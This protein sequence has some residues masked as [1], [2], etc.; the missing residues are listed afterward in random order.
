VYHYALESLPALSNAPVYSDDEE[1][2][3]G[4]GHMTDKPFRNGRKYVDSGFVHDMTD[5]KTENHYFIRAHVWPS[6]RNELPHNVL[7]ILSVN[8]GAV[9]HASCNPCKVSQLGRCSHVVA[10]LLSL[11]DHVKQHGSITSTPC[12]SKECSWNKGQKR[13]KTPKRLSSAHYPSNRKKS[14]IPV[15][16]FDPRLISCRTVT[17]DHI[18]NFVHDLQRISEDQEIS[19]WEVQ[20]KISYNDYQLEYVSLLQAK[21]MSLIKN[22]SPQS[23]SQI[24]NTT[25]QS[26]SEK[27]HSERRLRLTASKCLSAYRVGKLI[28]EG[29]NNAAFRAMKYISSNLWKQ[30][31]EP[32]AVNLDGI[33]PT[34]KFRII[35]Y[36]RFFFFEDIFHSIRHYWGLYDY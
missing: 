24:V 4:L 11:V 1:T 12:T 23:V 18:N 27:W 16:D 31:G 10:L 35:V 22:L 15:I 30:D 32:P 26:Q 8:S 7:V 3:H 29:A 28:I 34:L 2:D 33:W 21:I 17:S 13:K 14:K 25:E 36:I 5:A 20:L 6:M 19:M 9:I